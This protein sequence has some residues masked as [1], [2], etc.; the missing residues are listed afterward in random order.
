MSPRDGGVSEQEADA[1]VPT[2]PGPTVAAGE[3][4]SELERSARRPS[5]ETIELD[6]DDEEYGP[7]PDPIIFADDPDW[8]K[9][10]Y[11]VTEPQASKWFV[12]EMDALS[13]EELAAVPDASV[14]GPR[15]PSSALATTS[16]DPLAHDGPRRLGG[17]LGS[18]EYGRERAG[19][20]S[21]VEPRLLGDFLSEPDEE[22]LYRVAGVL[23]VGARIVFSAQYKTGK[24]TLR[25]NLVRSLADGDPFLGCF[26]VTPSDGRIVIIDDELHEGMLRRWLRDQG[27]RQVDR[28]VVVPLR[29]RV[30]TFDITNPHQRGEWAALLRSYDAKF[31]I[32]DCLRPVLDALGLSEDKDAGRFL[33]AFD[34]LMSEA[35]VDEAMVVH[36]MGHASDR[37]RGDTRL[38]DWP[39]AEWRLLRQS[40]EGHSSGAENRYF[41]AFGRDVDMPEARLEFDADSRRL[42]LVG[43]TRT[44]AAAERLIPLVL[45]FLENH[46]EASQRTVEQGLGGDKRADVRA[47]LHLATQRGLVITTPG[48]H[49]AKLHSLAAPAPTGARDSARI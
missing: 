11:G 42:T 27:I 31:V 5:S 20:L 24:S 37:P 16:D 41:A 1:S 33:V 2:A 12:T 15:Q 7:D 46:P 23:P 18:S 22:T 40:V 48:A 9:Q 49:R 4:T 32:L 35:E 3:A 17:A 8:M 6:G 39:D 44:D 43:G 26:D 30:A 25:D 21:T 36:H 45:A 28:V 13:P 29:G 38:R 19:A 47:A 10:K 14:L 34:G